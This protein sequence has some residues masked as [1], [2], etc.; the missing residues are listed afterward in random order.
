MGFTSLLPRAHNS[1]PEPVG[2]TKTSTIFPR[3][4]GAQA[5]GRCIPAI[6][7]PA[8]CSHGEEV[9]QVLF[10]AFFLEPCVSTRK[11]TT[12]RTSGRDLV[13]SPVG[14]HEAQDRPVPSTQ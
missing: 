14:A 5:R 7:Q 4:A 9:K 13:L 1:A 8:A 11:S 10:A 3:S 6:L 12:W 2:R